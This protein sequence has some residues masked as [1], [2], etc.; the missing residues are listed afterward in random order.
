MEFGREGMIMLVVFNKWG[1]SLRMCY[2]TVWSFA[3]G[4]LLRARGVNIS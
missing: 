2:V 3:V 4:L 1:A